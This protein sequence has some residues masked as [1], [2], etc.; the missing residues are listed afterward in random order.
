MKSESVSR[1]EIAA[2]RQNR[3]ASVSFTVAAVT[4]VAGLA[5][6][7]A[8]LAAS[9]QAART[10]L[11][12]G[13]V[14]Y[15]RLESAVST[16]TSHLREAVTARVVREVPASLNDTEIAIP[17]GAVVRG[18]VEKLVPSSSPTDRAR[19][20]LRFTRLEVPGRAPVALAARV[21]E[22]ENARETV[23]PDGTV[24]G[25]LAS[26]LPLTML[27]D[28]LARVR[29]SRSDIGT[30]AQK[31]QEEALGKADT[32][33]EFPAGA[34]LHVVLQEPL[35]LEQLFPPTVNAQLSSDV[36]ASLERLLADAPQRAS[37][38]DGKPGD[39]LNLIVVGSADEIRRAFREA[40][41]AEAEKLSGKSLWETVRAVAANKGYKEAPVSQLYLFGRAE[42]LAF[43]KML[44]TFAERHH[45]RLWRSSAA[46]SQGREIWLGAATHDVGW[47]IRPGVV[48]HAI[49][50]EIDRE[51]EKVG[52]DLSVTGRTTAMRF[53][54]RPNPLLEGLTATGASW[55][56][57]GQLLAIELKPQ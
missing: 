27:E 50:A 2:L 53:V 6:L 16:K 14:L 5:L 4:V 39:P 32:A 25:V 54:T 40:G 17:V 20:C 10:T 38:K 12:A 3:L 45:L 42:D 44:N 15:L 23:L 1:A 41:W 30:E 46:T 8:N 26:E 55:K 22:V 52:A 37:G 56:T 49:E 48:S 35:A 36:S 34:D 11:P 31:A 7:E 51:R 47:D 9:G 43:Q 13:S 24:Q 29:K 21:T 33:I 18:L 19:L 28:A 57:D